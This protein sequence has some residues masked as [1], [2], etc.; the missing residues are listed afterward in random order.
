MGNRKQPYPFPRAQRDLVAL[1]LMVAHPR[2]PRDE[3]APQDVTR[4][5]PI[6]R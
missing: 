3:R 1:S 6:A 4:F 2:N 5:D